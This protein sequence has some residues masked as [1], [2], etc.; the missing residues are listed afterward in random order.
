GHDG[1][2][3]GGSGGKTAPAEP[4]PAAEPSSH[5]AES[6][7]PKPTEPQAPEPQAAK[8]AESQPAKPAEAQTAQQTGQPAEPQGGQQAAP[9]TTY[10]VTSSRINV[11]NEGFE[12][13]A[14]L[15]FNPAKAANKSQ[16]TISQGE[17]RALLSDK[18]VVRSPVTHLPSGAYSRTITLDRPVG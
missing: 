14:G 4:P 10:G 5:P 6:Q 7:A 13:V 1:G 8:P 17:L 12:H 16:F 2:S 11:S 18:S 15:H 3:G 9:Q